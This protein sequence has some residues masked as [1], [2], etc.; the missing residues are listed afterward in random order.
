M[1]TSCAPSSSDKRKVT[2]MSS[3]LTP[4]VPNPRHRAMFPGEVTI[5]VSS[6]WSDNK[7]ETWEFCS[8]AV[9]LQYYNKDT[10][11]LLAWR[12]DGSNS[13]TKGNWKVGFAKGEPFILEFM[14]GENFPQ[15]S[16]EQLQTLSELVGSRRLAQALMS[17]LDAAKQDASWETR[18]RLDGSFRFCDL[19]DYYQ[20]MVAIG[21][22]IPVD[23][24]QP[25]DAQQFLAEQKDFWLEGSNVTEHV[26]YYKAHEA[27]GDQTQE[28]YEAELEDFQRVVEAGRVWASAKLVSKV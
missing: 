15:A 19:S 13:L 3:L 18:L 10:R 26:A 28:Q 6:S 24:E 1:G 9:R 7:P 21:S 14:E 23:A 27:L 11:G 2:T 25:F 22:Q 16:E 17:K 8:V 20:I 4:V 5:L 12:E